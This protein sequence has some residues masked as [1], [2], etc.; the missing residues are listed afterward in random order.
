[1]PYGAAFTFLILFNSLSSA[2]LA[3]K[4]SHRSC[5][6]IQKEAELPKN[7]AS[8]GAVPGVIPRGRLTGSFTRL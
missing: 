7:Y 1:M 3:W 5:R 6:F 4:R 8:R 2:R